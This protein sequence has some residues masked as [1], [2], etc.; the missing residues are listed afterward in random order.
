MS[1]RQLGNELEKRGILT[2]V[3][4]PDR[5]RLTTNKDVDRSDIEKTITVFREI[6]G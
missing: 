3:M 5:V 4:E 6:L 1:V 2:V